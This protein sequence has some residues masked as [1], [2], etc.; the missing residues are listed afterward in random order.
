MTAKDVIAA[1]QKV[2]SPKDAIFLQRFFKTGEGQYGAGDIFIGVRMPQ[3]REVCKQFR[4]LPLP[5]IQKLFDSKIHEHRMAAG[6][7]CDYQYPKASAAGKQALYNLYLKNVH[8]GR[9]NNW[10]LVDVT[11]RD[12]IGRHLFEEKLP[13]DILYQLARSNNLWQKRVGIIS[14]FYFFKGGEYKTILDLCEILLHDPHDLIQKAVGWSLR[15]VGKH[16]SRDILLAFLDRHAATMPRTAL[17]YAIEH[18]PAAQ[19]AQYMAMKNN[20]VQKSQ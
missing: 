3:I 14:C 13:R 15:E 17:R 19:K 6:V 10:D 4:E 8:A 20:S 5:E 16:C 12:V 7:I 2:A 9:L 11:C 18:L 1:L